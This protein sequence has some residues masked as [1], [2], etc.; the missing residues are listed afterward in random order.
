MKRMLALVI[1]CC[2]VFCQSGWA[3]TVKAGEKAVIEQEETKATGVAAARSVREITR[4]AQTVSLGGNY[5]GAIT[6]DGS[7]YMWGY[8]E[9]GEIGNGT[10]ADQLTP[11]KVL[12]DVVSVCL[13][14]M[15]Y[16]GAITVDGSLYMWGNNKFGQIGNGTTT[17]Q[18]TPIKVLSDVVS[19]SLGYGACGAITEDGSLYMWGYNSGGQIGNGKYTNQLT[20]TKVLSDVV[21]VKLNEHWPYSGAITKDGSLYMWGENQYGQVGNGTTADQ[22]TPV[23]VLSGVM[24]LELGGFNSGAITEDGSLYMWGNNVF[25]QIGNGVMDNQLAPIEVLSNVISLDLSV[26]FSSAAITE[27]D[28]LYVWGKDSFGRIG[29]DEGNLLRPVKVLS[30]VAAMNFG[31]DSGGVIMKEGSL[32]MQG[33]NS[34]GQVGNGTTTIQNALVKVLS[35]VVSIELKGNLDGISGE[36]YSGAVTKNGNLYMWGN[37]SHGKIGNGTTA[38]QLIPIKILDSVRLPRNSIDIEPPAF[39]ESIFR[40]NYIFENQ[41]NF[42]FLYNATPSGEFYNQAESTGL[43]TGAKAWEWITKSLDTIDDPSKRLDDSLSKMDFYEG[44]ILAL[45]EEALNYSDIAG[46]VKNDLTPF[47]E[48][49]SIISDGIKADYGIEVLGDTDISKMSAEQIQAIK[50]KTEDYFNENGF[51]DIS[52]KVSTVVDVIEFCEDI[53]EYFDYLFNCSQILQLGEGYKE[54]LQDML[55]SCPSGNTELYLALKDCVSVMNMSLE[56]LAVKMG[57]HAI[58]VAGKNSIKFA[59]SKF[60]DEVKINAMIGCPYAAAIWAGYKSGVYISDTLFNTS[61]IAEKVI[62]MN[63]VLDI[64]E[65][66][67]KA[68]ETEI[69][70]FGSLG[71]EPAAE[72]FLAAADICYRYINEDCACAIE[73]VD[74]VE[75]TLASK[76]RALF[77]CDTNYAVKKQIENIQ[78][79]RAN[80]WQRLTTEWVRDL[81]TD[82]PEEYE[83]Y[84]YLLDESSPI[85]ISKIYE[86]ACPVDVYVYDENNHLAASVTGNKV[87]CFDDSEMTVV[88]VDNQKTLYFYNTTQQ[89]TIQ[90]V[91]TDEGTMDITVS[92]YGE[93]QEKLRTVKHIDIPLTEGIVYMSEEDTG[94]S[95]ALDY[96]LYETGSGR[97]KNPD[98]DTADSSSER[99]TLSLTGGYLYDDEGV[100]RFS[101]EYY[102]GEKVTLYANIPENYVWKG[103]SV[104]EGQTVLSDMSAEK[105]TFIMPEGNL[106]LNGNSEKVKTPDSEGTSGEHAG[107]TTGNRTETV[108]V[109]RL[110]A[111]NAS[112]TKGD[113]KYKVTKSAANNGTVTVTKLLKKNKT[114]VTIP[115]KV[116]I[117]GYTFK[118]TGIGTRAFQKCKKLRQVTMGENVKSIGKKAFYGCNGLRNVV[119]KGTALRIVGSGAFKMTSGKMTVTFKSRKV[120]ARKRVALWKMMKKAGMS[121]SAQIKFKK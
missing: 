23:K 120:T 6:E 78:K 25:G 12:S 52:N 66:V 38:V 71:D 85:R 7:L 47:N 11:V 51:I 28:S 3:E 5:S 10:T 88:C 91:G 70:D 21:K 9:H 14:G 41:N 27:D 74:A 50:K 106:N 37:N 97:E 116:K 26:V 104:S 57:V 111:R 33:F 84:K 100:I 79:E 96:Q 89:Y 102:A 112:F 110:P 94:V 72:A 2:L 65:V 19:L 31:N 42:D 60:W 117:K 63:A 92:E 13:S 114:R 53:G 56:G 81:E 98:V 107:N 4:D 103:W 61:N 121:K 67:K 8:N 99:Y 58:A 35:N 93:G 22:L 30:N 101:G 45:F 40:A 62:N 18:F 34:D 29:T 69:E 48:Y 113:F 54:I 87:Y 39:N 90:Y 95:E 68:L 64:K 118:V 1:A 44:I 108:S 75:E 80:T 43:S 36:Y 20:P 115:A 46:S 119:V 17:N 24:R 83:D 86:I 32:Y 49:L 105:I 109:D 82:Y 73:F 59:I 16:G 77:Q 55:D 15:H 76:I